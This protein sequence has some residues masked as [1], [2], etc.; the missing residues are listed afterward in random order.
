MWGMGSIV[1]A[2][3][4]FEEIRRTYPRARIDFLSLRENAAILDLYPALGE[5]VLIDLSRGILPFLRD[6][7]RAL[8]RLRRERYDLLLDLEF[9]T[10]FSAILSFLSGARR[11]HG[12]TAKNQWRGRLHD[13]G[14][15]FNSYLHVSTNFLTLLRAD[16]MAPHDAAS[17][18]AE[19]LLPR[20]EP[21]VGEWERCRRLL[22]Q[23]GAW[24][25][26][27]PLVA[28]NPNA[29]YMAIE[30]RWPKERFAAFLKQLL[31]GLEVN[32]AL[33]G[34]AAERAYVEEVLAAAGAADRAV[35]LAGRISIAELLALYRHAAVV[36][37]ND[38][39]PL[40]I[41]SAAGASTVALFGPETPALYGPLTARP[42]QRH[43]VHYRR[44]GCS[45]CMFVH[46]NKV[47]SC[48][49]AQAECMTGI[50][51][52]EVL[53]SVRDLLSDQPAAPA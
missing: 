2:S 36:V 28:V 19:N 47:L 14:V 13:V 6:T 42:G 35:N 12:F 11:T 8:G 23:D 4:L 16:P 27:R 51:P 49:F 10:R 31:E 9:F 44:L 1:L 21:P 38:S 43:R 3:P 48:W 52:E 22:E 24:R 33:T 37:T 20:L 18:A 7:L 34:S 46:D 53:A 25:P 29:G 50:R 39:G 41:A 32:V 17:D 26:G 30:R 40:H 45:P 15:P 5:R